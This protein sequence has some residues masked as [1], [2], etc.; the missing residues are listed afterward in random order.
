[1]YEFLQ[2]AV[3]L[4][5]IA[6]TIIVALMVSVRLWYADLD[7]QTIVNP[8]RLIKRAAD[9]Q[10]GLFPT[11]ETDALYQD[12]KLV[13]RVE[14]AVVDEK[15]TAV[16]FDEIHTSNQL[17]LQREFEFQKWRLR[18]RDAQ[19]IIGLDTSAPHKGRIIREAV[20]E[21]VGERTL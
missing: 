17:D 20:C 13:A 7:L 6:A 1:M 21:I 2:I 15:A 8:Y 18:Y 9:A 10:V 5:L 12:R 14:K 11:R 19:A 4:I 16:R 3:K